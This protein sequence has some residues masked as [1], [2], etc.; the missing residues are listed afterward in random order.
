MSGGWVLE[1]YTA[2]PLRQKPTKS[3]VICTVHEIF[4]GT[5]NIYTPDTCPRSWSCC[6]GSSYTM[7][8]SWIHPRTAARPHDEARYGLPPLPSP[9]TQR[10]CFQEPAPCPAPPAVIPAPGRRCPVTAV[11]CFMLLTIYPVRQFRASRM[12]TWFLRISRHGITTSSRRR[13]IS[14]QLLPAGIPAG[15]AISP[16]LF[17]MIF[18]VPSSSYGT[19]RIL[20]GTVFQERRSTH[21]HISQSN[22]SQSP[23]RPFCFKKGSGERIKPAAPAEAKKALWIFP[24]SPLQFFAF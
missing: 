1:I 19:H 12:L 6:H 2:P 24:Q 13:N 11:Q 16:L 20:H 7:P 8:A 14:L 22:P 4:H 3:T 17:L 18:P 5:I 10:V 23:F 15:S 21:S 9:D